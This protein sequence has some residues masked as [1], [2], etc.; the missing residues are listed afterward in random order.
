MINKNLQIYVKTTETCNLNCSH[1]FTSGSKGPKIYFDPYRTF[2]FLKKLVDSERLESV[3]LLFHGGEPILAP[4]KDLIY[5]YD[6][7]KDLNT[8]V[9]Y[10]IQ[11]NLVYSLTSDKLKFF[12]IL[13]PYGI[14]TSWDENI[15]FGSAVP[16]NEEIKKKQL[17]IWED[18]VR[19]LIS[20]GHFVTLMVSLN[21]DIVEK[22]EP[23]EIIDYAAS[24][25][26]EYILFE[27]ITGNGNALINPDIFPKNKDIDNWI[28]RMYQQTIE[29]KLYLKIKNMFLN[30]IAH[31]FLKKEHMGNRCRNCELSLI[32]INADGSLSGC[33]NSASEKKW[34]HIDYDIET[35]LKNKNRI[36]AICKEMTR[37]SVCYS[38][39]VRDVCNGDCYKLPW[40]GDICAAPK[41]LMSYIKSNKDFE[42][43]EKLIV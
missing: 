28:F 33:P 23:F 25:G 10:G 42:N 35:S 26:I 6:L 32:T 15:R 27:R 9:S 37:N 39:P 29:R 30:E 11:T 7:T 19:K 21:K 2:L 41:S 31:S 1:C 12:D 16:G 22:K 5:F 4:L 3:R 18:N 14:G 24:L 20:E 43:L 17:S 13:K 36:G 34:G 40:E 8:S 38:C